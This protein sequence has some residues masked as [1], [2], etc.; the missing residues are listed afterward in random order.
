MTE[1]TVTPKQPNES[2]LLEKFAAMKRGQLLTA[3]D[4][5]PWVAQM[6]A[7]RIDEKQRERIRFL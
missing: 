1:N 3:R 4:R 2:C 6:N 7:L 5:T